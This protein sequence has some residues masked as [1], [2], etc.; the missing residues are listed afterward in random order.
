MKHIKDILQSVP[1][2]PTATSSALFFCYK[3]R[4]IPGSVIKVYS[5]KY[6]YEYLARK[7]WLME[8][9]IEQGILRSPVAWIRDNI[10]HEYNEP[11]GFW[12]WFKRKRETVMNG[13]FD[14]RIKVVATLI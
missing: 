11:E 2:K 1:L 13:D 6:S 4:G 14:T 9:K 5:D 12:E 3:K 8:F 7:Y 10:E